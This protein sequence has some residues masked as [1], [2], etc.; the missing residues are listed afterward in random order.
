MRPGREPFF[1]GS[2][3]VVNETAKAIRVEL[4][5]RADKPWIPKSAIHD[6][7]EVYG[8]EDGQDGE[9]VVERWFAEKEGLVVE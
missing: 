2:G 5:G 9:L 6:D 7:S 1:V 4:D 8:G 3:R